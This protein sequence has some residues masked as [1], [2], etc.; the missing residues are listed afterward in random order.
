VRISPSRRKAASVS[1]AAIAVL[2]D[3]GARRLTHR[4]V[5]AAA[6]LPAG[7]TSNLFRSRAELIA[8]ILQ[9][10]LAR[11]QQAVTELSSSPMLASSTFG[12]SHLI[13]FLGALITEALGPGRRAT[14]ARRALFAEAATDPVVAEQL[15]GASQYWFDLMTNLV[16]RA[17]GRDPR[18]RARWLMAY[19]DGLISHQLA[20]PEAD[21]D[22]TAAITPAVA[23]I[24]HA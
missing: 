17:G 1:E 5:D 22:P 4:A 12:E 14:L 6:R 8:G 19:G 13:A 11:E 20:R 16:S 23:G 9:Q 7:S 24:L 15:L 2:A 10:M 21:F 3:G 18:R